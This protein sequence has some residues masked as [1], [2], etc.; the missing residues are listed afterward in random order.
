MRA[1]LGTMAMVVGL[2]LT[3]LGATAAN[4]GGSPRR[5][6]TIS[7]GHRL[8]AI[9]ETTCPVEVSMTASKGHAEIF[10]TIVRRM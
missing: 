7:H 3:T 2:G 5:V 8:P 10:R 6:I 1:R 9:I 4:V